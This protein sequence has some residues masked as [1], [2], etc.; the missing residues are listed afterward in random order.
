MISIKAAEKPPRP[1]GSLPD[2]AIPQARQSRAPR[3]NDGGS[4]PGRYHRASRR[5]RRDEKSALASGDPPENSA[6]RDR[7]KNW[8]SSRS[9]N[10]AP[11]SCFIKSKALSVPMATWRPKDR[12]SLPTV[13]ALRRVSVGMRIRSRYIQSSA[14]AATRR[15]EHYL[16]NAFC[17]HRPQNPVVKTCRC[18]WPR[19]KEYGRLILLT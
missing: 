12:R 7:R 16:R 15:P 18:D 8:R 5:I 6:C 2:L 14:V 1:R 17:A 3:G 19:K 9:A 10:C 11:T 4:A 13:E